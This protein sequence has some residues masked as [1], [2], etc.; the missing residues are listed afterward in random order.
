MNATFSK[1]FKKLRKKVLNMNIVS[2]NF[3]S[4]EIL[5][6]TFI[7]TIQKYHTNNNITYGRYCSEILLMLKVQFA[8]NI[9]VLLLN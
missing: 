2:Q 5:L 9:S 7:I 8:E 1:Y 6:E 3:C 4:R